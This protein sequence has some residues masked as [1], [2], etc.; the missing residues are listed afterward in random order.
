MC[1]HGCL[2]SAVHTKALQDV[3]DI[4]FDGGF[5][6]E[7]PARDPGIVLSTCD[8]QENVPLTLREPGDGTLCFDLSS[9]RSGSILHQPTCDNRG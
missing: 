6:E 8:A 7:Q 3:A 1:E 4:T 5:R 9:H 2:H